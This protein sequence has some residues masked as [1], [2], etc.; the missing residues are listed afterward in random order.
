[1]TICH[2]SVPED[3]KSMSASL[4]RVNNKYY[5]KTVLQNYCWF[6]HVL[7]CLSANQYISK[8]VCQSVCPFIV[9]FFFFFFF[10][11]W[12][13]FFRSV[14]LFLVAVKKFVNIGR[15]LRQCADVFITRKLRIDFFFENVGPY[16]LMGFKP[17]TSN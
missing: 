17:F 12:C 11:F 13:F 3:P 14:Q 15:Y 2:L 9:L 6:Q 5:I 1:M 7:V 8:S 10:F 4:I 16:E